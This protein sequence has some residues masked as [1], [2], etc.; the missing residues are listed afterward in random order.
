M[1]TFLRR[2]RRAVTVLALAATVALPAAVS[3]GPD[4]VPSPP[5][6]APASPSAFTATALRDHYDATRADVLAAAETA[7]RHGHPH[8]AAALRELAAPGRHLL[9]FDG[10]DGGRVVEVYGDLAT[11]NRIAV[12]VPGAD[13]GVDRYR[14]LRRDAD[15]LQ[16]AMGDTGA[17]VA[18]LGYRPPAMVSLRILTADTARPAADDL[19]GFLDRLAGHVPGARL[20]LVCHSYGTVVCGQAADTAARHVVLLG[21]P[22][23]GV[24]HVTALGDADVWAARGERDW[25]GGLPHLSLDLGITTIGLGADPVSEEFGATVFDAADAGHDDYLAPGSVSLGNVAAIV[26]GGTPTL[27]DT[28]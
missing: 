1:S 23:A 8:R 11:A 21:S 25:V 17:V 12:L 9:A 20:S 15:A 5:P 14:R 7:E 16:T 2:A 13:T 27:P 28:R 3:S 6:A 4:A 22:G 10:R 26:T 18:W 24:D 19:T